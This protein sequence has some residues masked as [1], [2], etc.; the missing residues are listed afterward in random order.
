MWFDLKW[1]SEQGDA[2]TVAELQQQVD[3]LVRIGKQDAIYQIVFIV[4]ATIVVLVLVWWIHALDKKVDKLES[5][6]L[7][8]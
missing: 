8:K 3:V 6:L 5:A 4:I 1:L 2:T 7:E